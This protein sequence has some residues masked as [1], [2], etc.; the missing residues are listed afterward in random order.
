MEK[1]I[2][3]FRNVLGITLFIAAFLLASCDDDDDNG[4]VG[5][6]ATVSAVSP[7][8]NLRPGD[9]MTIAGTGLDQVKLL[10]FG[11]SYLFNRDHFDTSSDESQLVFALPD[12]AP[13]GDV[14]LVFTSE[15]VPNMLA[16]TISLV[17]PVI[18]GV[19]PLLVEAGTVVTVTGTDLNLTEN[20]MIGSV[21]LNDLSVS[22]D[23]TSL[24]ASCPDNI[25]GGVLK[26][27]MKNE[28][29]VAYDSPIALQEPVVLPEIASVSDAYLGGEVTIT[30]SNLDLVTSVVFMDN[31]PVDAFEFQSAYELKVMVP[32][33][34]ATGTVTLTLVTDDGEVVSPEFTISS[35]DPAQYVFFNFDDKGIGWNDL[36]GKVTNSDLS[37]DGTSFYEVDATVD[38]S[39]K[40]YF[41]DNSAGR[42]NIE[43]V[44][45]DGYALR[46]DLNV[47]AVDAGI[48]LKF[49]LG[50]FWY[51]WSVGD[52][53][54]SAG[55]DGWIAVY[56]P[57][58]E[59]KNDNGNGSSI[60]TADL[61]SVYEW[62][63]N[64]GWNGGYIHMRI[65][66]VGF[67]LLP[68][69]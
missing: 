18:S 5:S 45:A 39:W 57:L 13:G 17:T 49:R 6:V 37:V 31:Q 21:T 22:E 25:Q 51:A 40:S 66:N 56:V 19:G 46:F 11:T 63:L 35:V 29:E 28:T 68:A 43:G 60:T 67:A 54:S 20:V 4:N 26:L 7:N 48:N 3:H 9:Q 8:E 55:T 53:Y 62:G 50:D 38:G 1:I 69:E 65:D 10:R 36:G 42:L 23:H 27:V 47:L 52:T 44:S 64:S 61:A 33:S 41:S 24:T 12:D 59:F 30:G 2:Y 58:T 32:A 14:Y 34:A 16:G 15:I